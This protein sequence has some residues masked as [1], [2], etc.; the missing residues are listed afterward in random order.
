VQN[1]GRTS[2]SG[3]GIIR[4]KMKLMKSWKRKIIIKATYMRL[5]LTSG[6]VSTEAII[7]AV[8]ISTNKM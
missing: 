8:S 6:I 4:W 5:K 3:R 2:T 7:K 1:N